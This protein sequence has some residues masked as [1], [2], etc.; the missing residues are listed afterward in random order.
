M[1]KLSVFYQNGD[2]MTQIPAD[3]AEIYVKM[4]NYTLVELR[5]PYGAE[6]L[7]EGVNAFV[8]GRDVISE[9]DIDIY[10]LFARFKYRF[11]HLLIP[12]QK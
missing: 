3:L 10:E 2:K 1:P 11:L 5:K 4:S 6:F 8:K 7:G 9:N 12:G